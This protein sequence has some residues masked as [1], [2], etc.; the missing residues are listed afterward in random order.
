MENADAFVLYL[1]FTFDLFNDEFGIGID[2]KLFTAREHSKA[3]RRQQS[4]IFGVVICSDPEIFGHAHHTGKVHTNAGRAS[5]QLKFRE[6]GSLGW[7][8]ATGLI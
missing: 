8:S 7:A 1:I 5:R 2:L 6:M 3:Q 4:R